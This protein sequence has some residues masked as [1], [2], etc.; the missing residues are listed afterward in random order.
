MGGVPISQIVLVFSSA[1]PPDRVQFHAFQDAFYRRAAARG[2]VPTV[3]FPHIGG[4]VPVIVGTLIGSHDPTVAERVLLRECHGAIKHTPSIKANHA[5]LSGM[6]SF[7]QR[8]ESRLDQSVNAAG[9]ISSRHQ[10][11]GNHDHRM[12]EQCVCVTK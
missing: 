9:L 10:R 12:E 6:I 2:V 11:A 5:V 3:L 8:G 7:K 1:A 4:R